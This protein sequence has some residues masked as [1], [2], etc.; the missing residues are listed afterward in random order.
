MSG[1]RRRNNHPQ[2]DLAQNDSHKPHAVPGEGKP[3]PEPTSEF[4]DD[5]AVLAFDNGSTRTAFALEQP[6]GYA[7]SLSSA[8]DT[9]H[10]AQAIESRDARRDSPISVNKGHDQNMSGYSHQP[11]T[12]VPHE[13]FENWQWNQEHGRYCC[14]VRDS[15]GSV[16]SAL[17]PPAVG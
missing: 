17:K 7:Y 8:Q 6:T 11:A 5:R 12:G 10:R 4:P 2:S 9:T 13:I 1:Q 16:T 3:K 15:K 14:V